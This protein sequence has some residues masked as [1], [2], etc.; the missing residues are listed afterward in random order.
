MNINN[1]SSSDISG[2]Q[3]VVDLD[4]ATLGGAWNAT[5]D[6]SGGTFAASNVAW[7]GAL[8]AG[9]SL[10]AFGFCTETSGAPGTPTVVSIDAN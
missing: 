9:Q 5:V 2:W 4:G 1:D 6:P 8:G 3:L 7:N 10:N